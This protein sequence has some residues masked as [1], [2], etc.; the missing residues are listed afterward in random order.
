MQ[1]LEREARNNEGSDDD[2]DVAD[3]DCDDVDELGS[4][5]RENPPNEEPAADREQPRR[6]QSSQVKKLMGPSGPHKIE[7]Y[8]KDHMIQA[9]SNFNMLQLARPNEEIREAISNRRELLQQPNS[10]NRNSNRGSNRGSGRDRPQ[11]ADHK[12]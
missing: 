9:R 4:G 11:S 2:P 3:E 8:F 7:S 12:K 6:Q 5:N 1:L 10:N